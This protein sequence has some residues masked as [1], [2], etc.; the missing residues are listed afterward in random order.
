MKSLVVYYS[1]GGKT[2]KVAEA[3]AQQLGCEAVDVER[4]TPDV[5]G[6]EL[7]IVGSGQYVGKLHKTLQSFLDGLQ[8]SS[9]NKAAVFATAGGPDP[10]VIY[11]LKGALEAKGYI[12]V[13]SFKCRG[14]FLFFNWS[15]P[16]EEDL[17]NAKAF[18]NDLKEISSA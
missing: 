18:A 17:E 13:S 14:R 15:N 4:E 6:V 5:S 9:K 1:R 16:N 12:V 11:V 3:I 8:P 2:R 10:K 7:L